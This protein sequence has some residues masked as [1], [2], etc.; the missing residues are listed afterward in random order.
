MTIYLVRHADVNAAGRCYGQTDLAPIQTFADSAAL[1][2]DYLPAAPNA[3]YTSPLR[4]CAG[5][6]QHCYP[7]QYCRLEA[8]LQE[9]NF[10]EWENTPWQQI[11]RTALDKWALSPT[12][13]QLPGGEHLQGFHQRVMAFAEQCLRA[14]ET[15]QSI[16]VFTHAGVIRPLCAWY[17]QQSWAQWLN[18][19]VPLLS[20][21]CL[22]EQQIEQ[23]FSP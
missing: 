15:Q 13:F 6:A 12:D 19:P 3:I 1:L 8:R 10:G 4:R 23:T 11:A 20:V 7:K 21:T 14:T 5:L 16:V 2:A 22:I 17:R 9:V 18:Y